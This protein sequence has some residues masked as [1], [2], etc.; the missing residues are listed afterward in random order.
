[1][2]TSESLTLHELELPCP[3]TGHANVPDPTSLYDI[4]KR[5][6]RLLDGRLVVES[7][8]LENVDVVEPEPLERAL[9]RGKDALESVRS[10]SRTHLARETAVVGETCR[11]PVLGLA[12]RVERLGEDH[13]GLAGDLVL[14]EEFPEDHLGLAGRVYVGS[15][16]GLRLS[17]WSGAGD[18]R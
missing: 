15:V 8:T 14:L 9:D 2:S 6:H 18:P 12:V 5:L 7:V 11:S 10:Q 16:K 13:D 17:D 4:V 3:A 1:M